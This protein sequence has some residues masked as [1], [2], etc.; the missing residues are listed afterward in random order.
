VSASQY[1][2]APGQPP[3]GPSQPPP[4]A[5][6]AP[7][8]GPQGGWWR[9]RS[10]RARVA[11]LAVPL[12]IAGAAVAIVLATTGSDTSTEQAATTATIDTQAQ[13]RAAAVANYEK[14]RDTTRP[15]L[16]KLH[17]LDSRL[18]VGLNY[19]EYTDKVGDVNVAYDR[20]TPKI[21]GQPQC[22]TSVGIPAEAAFN[23]YV[24]ASNIWGECFDDINCDN[25]S[26][27]PD[28]HNHWN[29]ASNSI[30]SADRGLKELRDPGS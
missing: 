3:R 22:V 18:D 15:L 1:S 19:D 7:Q 23:Q 10:T 27:E 9:R 16:D 24:K 25:D 8:P 12:V 30:D 5:S 2:S 17:E 11:L 13:R 6:G 14:C 28:L 21:G 20:V 4:P 26:I 29:K